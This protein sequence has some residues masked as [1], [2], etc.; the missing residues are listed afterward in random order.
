[1]RLQLLLLLVS[2]VA[3]CTTYQPPPRSRDYVLLVVD[4][5]TGGWRTRYYGYERISRDYGKR[6]NCEFE[7]TEP[8]FWVLQREGTLVV[9]VQFMGTFGSPLLIV[10]MDTCGNV[11][12]W[13]RGITSEG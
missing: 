11:L 8:F 7:G 10:E 13:H 5:N 2:F 9:R 4:P 3:G 1:M 6:R 12:R